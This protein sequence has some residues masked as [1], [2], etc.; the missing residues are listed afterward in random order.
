MSILYSKNKISYIITIVLLFSVLT[1]LMGFKLSAAEREDAVIYTNTETERIKEWVYEIN[2]AEANAMTEE[3]AKELFLEDSMNVLMV[4]VF[5]T[6]NDSKIIKFDEE[7]YLDFNQAIKK[8]LNVRNDLKLF[9]TL[10]IQ[11]GEFLTDWAQD[12]GNLQ[13]DKIAYLLADYLKY[14]QYINLPIDIL[15]IGSVNRD[16]KISPEEYDLIFKEL[17]RIALVDDFTI[18]HIIGP[19]KEYYQKQTFVFGEESFISLFENFDLELSGYVA[20]AYK[21]D[22]LSAE[23]KSKIIQSTLGSRPVQM[24][25][26]DGRKLARGKLN[27]RAFMQ[28]NDLIIW[29]S[30]YSG[31]LESY[32]FQLYRNTFAGPVSYVQWDDNSFISAEANITD[33][34]RFE[35]ALPDETI[36]YVKVKDVYRPI[37]SADNFSWNW[38]SLDGDLE[39]TLENDVLNVRASLRY[40]NTDQAENVDLEIATS[41]FKF[42][43]GQWVP[44][45]EFERKTIENFELSNRLQTLRFEYESGEL[46]NIRGLVRIETEVRALVDGIL[47]SSESFNNV[48]SF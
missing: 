35:L 22:G 12:N 46:E 4:P 36:T 34:N 48:V 17:W 27:S 47:I 5:L 14:M 24:N 45:L 23:I 20:E 28:G 30:N 31:D 25:D 39:Y 11:E 3:T 6:N 43:A 26:F 29:I 44:F 32:G 41:L 42:D 2:K 9:A 1:L 38:R 15:D 33:D 40:S 13:T 16:I 7:I 21:R 37:Q 8:A 19:E 10:K 18:P